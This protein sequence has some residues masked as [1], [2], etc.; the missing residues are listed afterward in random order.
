MSFDTLDQDRECWKDAIS[1]L[2]GC[3]MSDGNARR[4]FGSLLSKHRLAARDVWPA[5]QAAK[6]CGTMDP[7]SYLSKAIG[8]HRRPDPAMLCDWS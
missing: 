7:R 3:G 4:Y 8:N 2:V 1:V 6:R 5:V